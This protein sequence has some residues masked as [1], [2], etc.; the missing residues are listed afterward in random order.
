MNLTGNRELEPDGTE[1]VEPVSQTESV[2]LELRTGL[3]PQSQWVPKGP[4][5]QGP[6]GPQGP[7]LGS[8]GSPPWDPMGPPPWVPMGPPPWNQVPTLGSHGTPLGPQ[9]PILYHFLNSIDFTSKY[10]IFHCF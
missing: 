4:G 7:T 10:I 1:P 5:P 9:G 8:H 2:E 3:G 6:M